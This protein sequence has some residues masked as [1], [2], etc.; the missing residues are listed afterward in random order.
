FLYINQT[1]FYFYAVSFIIKMLKINCFLLTVTLSFFSL[2]LFKGEGALALKTT[3][4]KHEIRYDNSV[5]KTAISIDN[6]FEEFIHID[7][8]K[9][10]NSINH[11]SVFKPSSNHLFQTDSHYLKVCD[12]LDVTL[13]VDKIIFPFHYFL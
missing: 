13:T 4:S 8:Q 1:Y 7:K 5:N 12:F 11:V 9:R 2:V 3:S 10:Q 6:S